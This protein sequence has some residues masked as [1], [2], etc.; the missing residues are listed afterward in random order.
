MIIKSKKR[1]VNLLLLAVILVFLVIELFPLLWMAEISFKQYK[2]VIAMPP[3]WIFEPTLE[4]YE[5]VLS[6]KRTPFYRY[7][8]NSAIVGIASTFLALLVGVPAAY[9]FVRFKFKGKENLRFWILTTRMAPPIAVLIPYF[10]VF[11]RLKL[12]DSYIAVTLMHI[13]L[14]LALIVWMAIS[15]IKEVPVELEE[16]AIID[17]CSRLRSFFKITLP[18]MAPGLAAISILAFIFSWNDLL[19]ALILT[20]RKTATA[21]VVIT[22]FITYQDVA[23]GKLSSASMMIMAPVIVFAFSVQK[24]ILRGLTFGAIK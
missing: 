5:M 20:G 1:W 21:P 4:N 14:N 19:F 23:W 8:I 7:F 2:D 10:V 17:G 15:F 22:S 12:I 9:G 16:A 11:N 18:L 24:Y 6:E 13:T 3:K